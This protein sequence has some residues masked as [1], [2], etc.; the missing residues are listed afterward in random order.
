MM[1]SRTKRLLSIFLMCVMIFPVYF[2]VLMTEPVSAE[3]SPYCFESYNYPGYFMRH[4]DYV[5]YL[6]SFI[7]PVEDSEFK[8]VQG[9]A[10]PSAISFESVNYPGY[11]FRHYDYK[12]Q[13]QKNDGTDAF[14][15]DATFRK[16]PGLKDSNFVSFQSYNFP[17]RYIRHYNFGLQIDP[18]SND[19]DKADATFKQVAAGSIASSGGTNKSAITIN[20]DKPQ[21]AISQSLYG[22]FFED[23]NHAADGGLYAELIRNRSFEDNASTPDSWSLVNSTGSTGSMALDTTN[24][25]NS[26][27]G[28]S[29]KLTASSVAANGRIGIANTGFWGVN[30]VNG[31]TYTVTFFA[32]CSS[33]YNGSIKAS[34]ENADST[35]KY[36]ET[37]VTG[38]TTEWKKFTAS[39]KASGS[40]G[41]GRFLLSTDKPGTIWF[42]VVSCFPPTYKDRPNGLR[43]DLLTM[44][45]DLKP[46]FN[47]FP[48]GCFVEGDKMANAFRWKNTIGPIETR[49]GHLNL[50]GYRTSDGMG[51]HEFLQMCEDT[52][53]EPLYVCNV[54]M[55]HDDNVPM[56]PFIQEA[57]DAIEYANGATTTTWGAKRAANGHPEPFNIKYVE[58]GNEENFQKA[59]YSARYQSFYNAIKAKYPNIICIANC[60]ISGSTIDYIDEHYYDTPQFFMNNATKYDKY[61]RTGPKIYVG[62]YA[63]TKNCGQGNLIAAI[64]E[65]AFMTGL[66]RNSDVVKMASYAPLYV[67]S[68]DRKWNPDAIVY[69]SS[70]VYGTPSYYAQKMFSQNLG[71]NILLTTFSG[72]NTSFFFTTSKDNATGDIILKAV[73]ATANNENSTIKINGASYIDSTG[74]AI[75]MS[76]SDPN[77]ENSFTAPTKVAPVTKIVSGISSSFDYTFS[78]YSVT[79]LRIKTKA[80]PTSTPINTPTPTSTIKPTSTPTPKASEDINGDGVVNMAD[81]ILLAAHFNAV[82]QDPNF[83]IKCDLNSDNAINI[84]DV[85]MIAVKFNTI[86]SL[87]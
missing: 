47:R 36:A 11:Y 72:S 13:L 78:P 31:A 58:I 50:W 81:V 14:K 37:T 30:I 82:A 19:T 70:Q 64:G 35:V 20:A 29:L 86:I 46:R 48:G 55:A 43:N 5:G 16:V 56:E 10:D 79:V 9:L 65:A 74:S 45:N 17:T 59:T 27:Q 40:N 57:L 83:D 8:L 15:Q 54:G 84:S 52:N 39:M 63:V 25:L 62:E 34:M 2:S 61:V 67:N 66:E 33:G 60:D 42:D 12:L 69:N 6:E 21:T 22:I 71:S 32:K 23:I 76:N 80:G 26:A 68:N 77:A 4:Y 73:N 3:E 24:N 38:L 85:M 28:R 87:N 7:V 53:S 1:Y 75:V 44:V 41:S 18:I 51:Y 49:T